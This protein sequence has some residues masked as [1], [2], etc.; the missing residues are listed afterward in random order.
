MFAINKASQVPRR[1]AIVKTLEQN[2]LDR[3]PFVI[4]YNP[5]LSNI[6]KLLQ[7]SQTIVNASEKC[8][9]IFKN[10]PL[11]SYMFFVWKEKFTKRDDFTQLY[12]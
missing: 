5:P 2:K 8:S 3:V 9:E 1:E 6:P 12:S 11:V 7:E 4:A 10:T